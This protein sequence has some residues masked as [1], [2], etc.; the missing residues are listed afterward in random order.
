MNSKIELLKTIHMP[1]NMK[2]LKDVLP[3][4]NYEIETPVVETMYSEKA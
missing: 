4:T 1:K 3:P 2:K